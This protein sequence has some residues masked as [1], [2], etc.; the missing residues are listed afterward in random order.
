M[1]NRFEELKNDLLPRFWDT[2]NKEMVYPEYVH[3]DDLN[4]HSIW[5]DVIV[6]KD[7]FDKNFITHRF[8]MVDLLFNP[9]FILMKPTGL[10][11]KNGV[12]IYAGDIIKSSFH[13]WLVRWSEELQW[14]AEP[15]TK[16]KFFTDSKP[17]WIVF[18]DTEI[19]HG[20]IHANPEL[21]KVQK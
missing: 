18:D 20:N 3:C 5:Y 16:E 13:L 6:G 4:L 1:T 7:V 15:L 9:R 21:I 19:I 14:L 2:E 8:E 11:D 17:L 12:L 10:K